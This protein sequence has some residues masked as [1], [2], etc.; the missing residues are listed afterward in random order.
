MTLLRTARK[1]IEMSLFQGST[2]E[3]T[4]IEGLFRGICTV[5]KDSTDSSAIRIC[6]VMLN[7][8]GSQSMT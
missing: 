1:D 4:T 6:F 8:G 3:G 7:S 2:P 5:Y